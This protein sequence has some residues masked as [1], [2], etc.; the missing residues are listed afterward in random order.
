MKLHVLTVALEAI[1]A[2]RPIVQAVARHDAGLAKQM[3]EAGSSVVLNLAEGLRS[4]PGNAR[5][6][7]YSAAGSTQETRSALLLASAWGYVEAASV[8][9]AEALFDRVAAMLYRLTHPRS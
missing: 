6:R 7:F 3:R 8:E 1:R 5:A 2:L 9:P 4:D